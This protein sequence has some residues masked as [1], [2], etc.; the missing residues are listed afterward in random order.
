[1]AFS[2]GQ[3]YRAGN[4]FNMIGAHTDSP[5]LKLKPRSSRVK[6]DY[7]MV[8][9]EPYGG[10]LWHTWFDRDLSVAGRVLVKD[11][12]GR[13]VHRLVRIERPILR[14]PM[15]AIHLNREI[16][17][18]GFKPNKETHL[19]PL[20]ATSAKV[21]LSKM[22]GSKNGVESGHHPI[23]LNVLAKELKCKVEDIVDFEL[24]LC[25]TQPGVI[26]GASNE[27]VFVGRLDNLCSCF[28][29]IT[30]LIDSCQADESLENEDRIRAVALFD[31][32]EV[33]S[34]SAQGAGGPVMHDTISR[35]NRCL[36]E[37]ETDV[38][39]RSLASSFLVSADMAHAIHPNYTE[40]HDPSHAPTLH[41][42]V[43]VKTNVNQRYA[44]NLVSAALFM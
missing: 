1:M 4:G 44:T 10:G 22:N 41:K 40:K 17:T 7:E 33:G 21:E 5:C 39:E 31:H 37:R 36:S 8:N 16:H 34:D 43:V 26:A 2:I 30:A 18:E 27:F 24:N 35:V 20:L 14:I 15:L 25:D 28:C 9:V 12:S 13:F 38:V 6:S 3:K 29:S 42:G 32:E 23:L 11:P 19:A